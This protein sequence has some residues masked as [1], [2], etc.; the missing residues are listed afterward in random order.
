MKTTNAKNRNDYKL[1]IRNY[2]VAIVIE[3]SDEEGKQNCRCN[4]ETA[5]FQRIY[6]YIYIYDYRENETH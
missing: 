3:C 2:K 1:T 4:H 5:A 6:I